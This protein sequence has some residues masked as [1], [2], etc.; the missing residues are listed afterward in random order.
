MNQ[1]V[2]IFGAHG[3]LGRETINLCETLNIPYF[4]LDRKIE[5]VDPSILGSLTMIIDCGFPRDYY[6]KNTARNYLEQVEKR[7]KFCNE[8]RIRYVYLTTFTSVVS[9]NSKYAHLKNC[10]ED[11]V[12]LFGGELL[13]LGLVVDLVNP[14]GRFLELCSIIQKF[15]IVFVPSSDWFPIFT[16]TICEYRDE[17]ESLLRDGSLFKRHIGRLQSL[18]DVIREVSIGKKVLEL[19]NCVTSLLVR[20]LPLIAFGKREGIRGISVRMTDLQDHDRD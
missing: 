6:N 7:S 10:T 9:N 2:G 17:V 5:D 16:C 20:I 12:E 19:G 3:Y 4:A 11:T 15:P 8:Q 14:G 1:R 18:S 13:R